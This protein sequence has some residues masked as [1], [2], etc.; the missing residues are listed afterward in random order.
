MTL[1]ASTPLLACILLQI[2]DVYPEP[3]VDTDRIN[4]AFRPAWEAELKR[5]ALAQAAAKAAGTAAG[6]GS[7]KGLGPGAEAGVKAAA[8]GPVEVAVKEGAATAGKEGGEKLGGEKTAAAG[9][10]ADGGKGQGAKGGAAEGRG[11]K[12]KV[13]R[14]PNEA[15]LR[16]TI[17]RVYLPTLGSTAVLYALSQVRW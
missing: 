17:V 3:E 6:K 5:A 16:R 4:A 11:G 14:D 1:T 10:P 2:E 8:G 9:G 12:A 7:A 15:D 13:P